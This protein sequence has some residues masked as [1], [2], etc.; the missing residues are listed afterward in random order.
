VSTVEASVVV[1]TFNRPETLA[2]TLQALALQSL[3]PESYEII[4]VDDGSLPAVEP[5]ALGAERPAVRCVR[6]ENRGVAAARNHG[7]RLARGSTLVFIDDDMLAPPML[8]ARHLE[9]LDRFPRALV[10]SYWEYE[11]R[12]RAS[13]D[14]TPFGRYRMQVEMADGIAFG[15]RAREAGEQV[16]DVPVLA[17]CNLSLRAEHFREIGGFD[18]G[19]P[20]AGSEDADLCLRAR[21]LG[22]RLLLDGRERLLNDDRRLSF[23]QYCERQRRGAVSRSVLARKHGADAL[24]PGPPPRR[25]ARDVVK[26]VLARPALLR[27]VHAGVGALERVA[28]T[29]RLLTRSYSAVCGLYIYRGAREASRS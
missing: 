14:A 4:V 7:A 2:A 6:Q 26:A 20:Y 1:P 21:A 29:S 5:P 12:L 18:E 27:L 15:T 28:P 3:D 23:R 22:F 8:L 11:P 13:L 19:F 16:F 24:P 17:A 9:L 10:Q 25:R